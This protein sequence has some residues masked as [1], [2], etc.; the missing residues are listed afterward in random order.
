M[1]GLWGGYGE[2]MV[3]R[4]RTNLHRLPEGIPAEELTMFEPL[5]NAVHWV[6]RAGWRWATPW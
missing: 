2:Q 3:I 5:A 6:Q 4:P 1:A